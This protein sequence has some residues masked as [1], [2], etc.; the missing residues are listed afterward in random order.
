MA[1]VAI[2]TEVNVTVTVTVT[3]IGEA[4]VDLLRPARRA[5]S[6]PSRAESVQRCRRPGSSRARRDADGAARRY[7]VRPHP[8][9]SR[10][11][12]GHRP[13]RRPACR[14]AVDAGRGL[15]GRLGPGHYLLPR[16]HGRLAVDGRGDRPG[17]R[18]NRGAPLRIDRVL[19]AARRRQDP[20]ARWPACASAATYSSPTTR[21]SGLGCFP[22]A[23]TA[24]A[25]WSAPS[26]S[27]TWP[28]RA[29]TTSSGSIPT[30][31]RTQV[32]RH[33]LRLGASTVVMTSSAD[34]SP[35]PSPRRAGRSAGRPSTWPCWTPWAPGTRSSPG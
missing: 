6:R 31:R 10:P 22:I 23:T 14:G 28:R 12:R 7:R 1:G 30:R 5:R 32:A 17:A 4:I 15:D 35:R 16:G 25:W 26:R 21:T 11:G 34:N 19:D 13:A 20:R 24:G 8:A 2:K 29:R 27:L 18:G 9:R 3:V 33:W